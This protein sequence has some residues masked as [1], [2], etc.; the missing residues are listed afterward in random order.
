MM[1]DLSKPDEALAHYLSEWLNDSAP[2]G[3]RRYLSCAK[4][5]LAKGWQKVEPGM[6]VVPKRREI[7]C[8]S[9]FARET[10]GV[11]PNTDW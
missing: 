3:W 5:M 4:D 2:L 8:E 7:I 1:P 10:N 11:E 6:V 9:C